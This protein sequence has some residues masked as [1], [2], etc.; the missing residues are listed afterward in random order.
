[1]I[2][3]GIDGLSQGKVH[4][5]ALDE[6]RGSYVLPLHLNPITQLPALQGWL[7]SW[8]SNG[9]RSL[10]LKIGSTRPSRLANMPTH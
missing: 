5:G 10:L 9:I 2:Q 1:M 6:A 4:L 7:T 8:L 3:V